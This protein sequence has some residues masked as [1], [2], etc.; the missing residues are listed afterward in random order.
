MGGSVDQNMVSGSFLGV[1]QYGCRARAMF[2]YAQ[3]KK[4]GLQVDS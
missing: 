1:W 4:W 3:M 2:S